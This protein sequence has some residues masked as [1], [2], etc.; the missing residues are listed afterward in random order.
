MT[1]SVSFSLLLVND[2]KMKAASSVSVRI[3]M[4][5][6]VHTLEIAEMEVG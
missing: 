3:R 5:V 4:D 2:A 6:L 1:K